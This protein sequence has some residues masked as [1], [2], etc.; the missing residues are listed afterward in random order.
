[1]IHVN[2]E[3]IKRRPRPFMANGEK[4]LK[5]RKLAGGNSQEHFARL[6]GIS[7][8]YWIQLETGEKLPSGVVRDKIASALGCDPAEIRSSDDEDEDS[9]MPM[10]RDQQEA[11]V[12]LLETLVARA[13]DAK[14]KE[15]VKS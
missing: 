6:A 14:T 15:G 5:L 9:S 7:R 12:G 3:V 11:F 4:I 13:V 2:T 8:R 10:T 1:M